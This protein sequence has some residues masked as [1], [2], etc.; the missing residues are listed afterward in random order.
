L[1]GRGG[2]R[3]IKDA[4]KCNGSSA[5]GW[6]RAWVC[7]GKVGGGGEGMDGAFVGGVD[8]CV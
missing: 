2:F 7:Y 3:G 6:D 1:L 5:I 8:R 4:G